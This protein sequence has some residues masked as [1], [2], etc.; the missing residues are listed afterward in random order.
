MYYESIDKIIAAW[1]ASHALH[2]YTTS[3][4][5]EVRSVDIVG[6]NGLKCELWM[7]TPDEAGNI[8]V[9]V[10]DYRKQKECYKVN[11]SG[12]SK[13]LEDAFTT[14]TKWLSVLS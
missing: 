7:E 9:H 12:L 14:A 2:I 3:Q 4:D 13:C 5:V 6:S 8:Q 10:W 11:A 1:A